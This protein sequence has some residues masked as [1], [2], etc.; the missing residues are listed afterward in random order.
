MAKLLLLAA[1]ACALLPQTTR[2]VALTPRM[3]FQPGV[4]KTNERVAVVGA[5]GYIGKAVVRECVRR[6]YATTAVTRPASSLTF[7]GADMGRAESSDLASIT[8][9][10]KEAQTEVV[11][12]CLASRSGTPADSLQVDYEASVNCLKA[13]QACGARHFVLL[14]AF[15]VAKPDLGF[16][17]A[18]LKTEAVLEAQTDVTFSVVRP[19]AFFKS[20]S[21]QVEI[22][23]GGGPFVYFDL[24]N[25]RSATCN[26]ISEADLAMAIVDTVADPARSSQGGAPV[27]NVGGPDAGV[28]MK[29]QGELIADAIASATGEE[30][31]EPWLL[32][33]PIGVFD[34]IVGAIE[35]AADL[36]G[37]PGVRD[38]W[39]LG[40]IGRYYAVEDMLTTE[41]AER[42][43]AMS[44]SEHYENVAK[45]GQEYDPYTTVFAK[46][47]LMK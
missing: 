14:S 15:C 27:W 46:N 43:G 9:C 38:A 18:K 30:R 34:G 25:G 6:G 37:N 33:V 12:C 20:L 44:L 11:I 2:R 23:R 24:G 47:P 3:S 8:Q 31:K 26:P 32:G 5:S 10:F 1:S 22:V 40:K 13:A 17:L 39:E 21:G 41:P 29:R 16:Q 19:T 7:E 4:S 28:S 35:W 45:N 42:Y 36:T